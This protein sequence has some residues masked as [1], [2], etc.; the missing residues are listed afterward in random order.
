VSRLPTTGADVY[1][2][3]LV[4]GAALGLLVASILLLARW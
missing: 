1:I 2:G 3:A 4:S